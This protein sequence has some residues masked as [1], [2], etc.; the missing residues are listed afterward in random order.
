[1]PQEKPAN[2]KFSS[3]PTTKFPGWTLNCLSTESLGRSHRA[4]AEK[5]KLNR[6]I[7]DSKSLLGIPEDYVVGIVPGSDTGAFELAMWNLL[8]QRGVEILSWESFGQGWLSDIKNQLGLTDITSHSAD[9]GQLPDLSKVDCN[10]D[11]VFTWNGTTSGVRVPNGDW[12][13]NDREGLTLCDA[14]SAVFAMDMPWEKLDVTTWSWQKVLGGEGGQ[15]MIA[16]SPRAVERLE[17]YAP[18]WP[19]PKIFR[20]TKS[21]KLIGGI[22]KGATINTPSMLAVEDQI[23]ALSWASSIGKLPGLIK[24]SLSNLNVVEQFVESSEWLAFLCEQDNCRSST[25]ICL[26]IEDPWFTNGTDEEQREVVKKICSLLESE[27]VAYD[28]GGHRDA[29]PGLRI[30]GGATVEASDIKALM[31]WLNW[32]YASVKDQ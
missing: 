10:R 1:M 13:S 22:F 3:G 9:Y 4:T 31:P 16:L 25:S 27:D 6:L 12:I 21:G 24:R 20:L 11:V 28:I 8:G 18:A 19:L 23:E 15:G 17:Q 26:K 2:P 29:P 5:A 30:W 14:T 7:S 32:A